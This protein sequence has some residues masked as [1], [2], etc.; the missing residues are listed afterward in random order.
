M[1]SDDMILLFC[2]GCGIRLKPVAREFLGR[3]GVCPSCGMNIIVEEERCLDADPEATRQAPTD[4]SN[5]AEDPD[6]TRMSSH[7]SMPEPDET[8]RTVS[9]RTGFPGE[10][11]GDTRLAGFPMVP[12]E[13][14]AT[15]LGSS[16]AESDGDETRLRPGTDR[17]WNE[18]GDVTRAAGVWSPPA[19]EVEVAQEEGIALEWNLG[20]LILDTYRVDEILGRGAFGVV[21]KVHHLEWDLDL[22]VKSPIP[23]ALRDHGAEIFVAEAKT[24]SDLGLYPHIVSCYYVRKLGGI[25][26]AFAEFVDGASL[27]QLI[28]RG[29]IDDIKAKLDV[30]IQVA[31]GLAFAHGYDLVHQD[32][33]PANV[34]VSMD[35]Q[36]KIT[37]FG[38]ARAK[39]AGEARDVPEMKLSGDRTVLVDVSGCTPS[40]ASPEQLADTG[41]SRATDAWSFGVSLLAMFTGGSHWHVGSAAPTV[42]EDLLSR[43]KEQRT[44]IPDSLV[45]LMRECFVVA[46]EERLRDMEQIAT[47]LIGIY[48]E[49][50]SEEYPR[51]MPRLGKATNSSSLVNRALSQLDLGQVEQARSLLLEALELEPSHSEATYNLGLMRWRAGEIS[52][53]ELV[54]ELEACN[55]GHGDGWIDLLTLGLVHMERGAHESAVSTLESIS[56]E[57]LETVPQIRKALGRSREMA[58]RATEQ[59]FDW[60]FW[61]KKYPQ[62]CSFSKDHKRVIFRFGESSDAEVYEVP[63]GSLVKELVSAGSS[64]FIDVVALTPDGRQGVAGCLDWSLKVWDLDG[65]TPG[66]PRLIGSPA[67]NTPGNQHGVNDF[68]LL[69]TGRSIIACYKDGTIKEWV[70]STGVFKR[71]LLDAGWRGAAVHLDVTQDETT[72]ALRMV[73]RSIELWNLPAGERRQVLRKNGGN[74]NFFRISGDGRYVVATDTDRGI[75]FFDLDAETQTTIPRVDPYGV[76]LVEIRDDGRWAVTGSTGGGYLRLWELATGRC[77]RTF[78]RCQGSDSTRKSYGAFFD[79]G[80]DTVWELYRKGT[81]GLVQYRYSPMIAPWLVCRVSDAQTVALAADRFTGAMDHAEAFAEASDF[82]RALG[83]LKEARKQPGFSRD[84]RVMKLAA[85]LAMRLPRR[86]LVGGWQRASIAAH[87]KWI[88][89]LTISPDGSF[90]VTG[91]NTSNSP[92]K[93]WDSMGDSQGRP[94]WGLRDPVRGLALTPD[95]GHVISTHSNKKVLLWDIKRGKVVREFDQCPA[96]VFSIGVSKGGGRVFGMYNDEGHHL[97][98]WDFASG[99]RLMSFKQVSELRG[100]C[101]GNSGM[102]L[103]T[104]DTKG[105]VVSMDLAPGNRPR[106]YTCGRKRPHEVQVAPGGDVILCSGHNQLT[107]LGLRDGETIGTVSAG[108]NNGISDVTR[109]FKVAF[110]SSGSNI[111]AWNLDDMSL[112]HVFEG[113]GQRV[114]AIAVSPQGNSL[115]SGDEGGNICVWTLDWELAPKEETSWDDSANPFVTDFLERTNEGLRR[116]K[117]PPSTIPWWTENAFDELLFTLRCAG[118]GWL[119]PE[120]IRRKVLELAESFR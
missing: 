38:L 70:L 101:V 52:D 71:T 16:T 27:Q 36:A 28:E 41:V 3:R 33:K 66:I 99:R 114:S 50:T 37:D 89:R 35:G 72:L 68:R 45:A 22:A 58:A 61:H 4:I 31:W 5:P 49:E 13:S 104:W 40:F 109:D 111:E 103:V 82:S 25:P 115:V 85:R 96:C 78:R 76:T 43:P 98:Y 69:T 63:S 95:G 21:Y 117:G 92:I 59:Y 86:K 2:P 11:L 30:A 113:H 15:R 55:A 39:G 67:V 7:R 91:A 110:V 48:G 119:D 100:F 42:L 44:P 64:A 77:L 84:P 29:E 10:D 18:D 46:P 12:Q 105:M 23:E 62:G 17:E 60:G 81:V 56:E 94:F 6:A 34:M 73:D 32:V 97:A 9:R 93:V 26:R 120:G 20:D 106:E 75:T 108:D 47:R 54:H 118:L 74:I 65:D 24:W 53:M 102:K 1:S 90:F 79:D 57:W 87:D 8:R 51:S 14:D 83:H 88:E 112:S 19:P 107:L 80:G 116:L